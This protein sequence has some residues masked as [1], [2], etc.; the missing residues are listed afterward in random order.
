MQG[1]FVEFACLPVTAAAPRQT[2]LSQC[3]SHLHMSLRSNPYQEIRTAALTGS[4]RRSWPVL[5][6]LGHVASIHPS[7]RP[8]WNSPHRTHPLPAAWP[9]SS[10][11][12]LSRTGH[13]VTSRLASML[14]RPNKAC[15]PAESFFWWFLS[16]TSNVSQN[17]TVFFARQPHSLCSTF[18][19][20]GQIFPINLAPPTNQIAPPLVDLPATHLPKTF[21]E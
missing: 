19:L 11:P 15:A 4:R 8:R 21:W 17:C 18:K 13:D 6:S 20:Y 5:S 7:N 9:A 14:H 16:G 1:Y 12:F 10:P 3:H 2:F